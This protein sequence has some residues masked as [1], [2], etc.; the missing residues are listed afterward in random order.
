[1][2]CSRRSPDRARKLTAGLHFWDL[3][4]RSSAARWSGD[5]RDRDISSQMYIILEP[6]ANH[7]PRYH[8]GHIIVIYQTWFQIFVLSHNQDQLL[9]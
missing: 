9:S 6:I 1:M 8:H 3:K 5:Q 7:I 2:P 4:L